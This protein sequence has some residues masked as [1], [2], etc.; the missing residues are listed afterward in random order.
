MNRFSA[1]R[2]ILSNK[3]Q[4]RSKDFILVGEEYQS[5]E[6][7]RR[8]G[9]GDLSLFLVEEQVPLYVHVINLKN[10]RKN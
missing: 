7:L 1:H 3:T 10:W 9:G 5:Q 2:D 8:N 6:S 4:C